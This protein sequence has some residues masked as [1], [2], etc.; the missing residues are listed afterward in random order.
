MRTAPNVRRFTLVETLLALGIIALVL[1]LAYG[2]YAAAT[3]SVS[4]CGDRAGLDMEARALMDRME[5]EMRCVCVPLSSSDGGTIRTGPTGTVGELQPLLVG[6]GATTDGEVLH[7][8]TTGGMA[9][10]DGPLPGLSVVRYRLDRASRT[11]LRS[12]GTLVDAGDVPARDVGWLP[13]ARDVES[14]ALAYSD[15]E[16]WR[17]DWDSEDAGALP[18]AVHV[19]VTL[20]GE[21]TPATT[22]ATSVWLPCQAQA[23]VRL[24]TEEAAEPRADA[25]LS[26]Q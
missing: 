9:R 13:V 8:V 20:R 24:G 2:T 19:E 4:R 5:R 6:R 18:A 3:Q 17:D 22:F 12:Q 23:R 25:P 11:L 21:D 16:K 7:F 14:V 15:G 1:G 10:Q 26:E